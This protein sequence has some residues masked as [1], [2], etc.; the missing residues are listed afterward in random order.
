[1]SSYPTETKTVSYSSLNARDKK[2]ALMAIEVV[3]LIVRDIKRVQR[4][5]YKAERDMRIELVRRE[6]HRMKRIRGY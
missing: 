1:M 3:D 4:M 6:F 2:L 5:S